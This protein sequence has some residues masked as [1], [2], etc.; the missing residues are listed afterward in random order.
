MQILKTGQF[1]NYWKTGQRKTIKIKGEILKLHSWQTYIYYFI[2]T[3]PLKLI[4]VKML[5]SEDI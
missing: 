2:A 1:F 4:T 3:I 5:N